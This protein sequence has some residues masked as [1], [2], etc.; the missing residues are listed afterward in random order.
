MCDAFGKMPMSDM[1]VIPLMSRRGSNGG[2][3][4]VFQSE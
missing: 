2:Y 4:G 1:V 3:V